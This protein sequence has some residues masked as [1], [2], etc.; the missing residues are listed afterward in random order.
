MASTPRQCMCVAG[1]MSNR[2]L[3]VKDKDSLALSTNCHGNCYTA[4]N[5]CTDC[6]GWTVEK[7]EKGNAYQEKLAI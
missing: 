7:R 1:E 5:C 4:D 3:S 6:C 2:F